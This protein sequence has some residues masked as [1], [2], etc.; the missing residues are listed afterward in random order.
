MKTLHPF[1]LILI[2]LI[3]LATTASY[4]QGP[5]ERAMSDKREE[6]EAMK[7]GF[8]TRRL[9]LSAEEAKR[10]WPV[11]DQFSLEIRNLREGRNNKFREAREDFDSMSEKDIEK[12]VDGEIAFRQQ[13][14]DI[15]RKYHSSFKQVLPIRKVAKLYRAEEDFKRELLQKIKERRAEHGP[16]PRP[17]TR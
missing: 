14:L 16:G 11:Y 8:L 2:Y 17:G 5:P 10:F 9:N 1:K 7:V 4:A 13:E 6:I 12:L 3:L 15:V